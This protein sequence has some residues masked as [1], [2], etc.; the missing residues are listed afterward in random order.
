MK[1]PVKILLWIFAII[2]GGAILLFLS[3]PIWVS[4]CLNY[5]SWFQPLVGPQDGIWIFLYVVY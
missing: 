5:Q 2:F 4:F 3:S 1:K